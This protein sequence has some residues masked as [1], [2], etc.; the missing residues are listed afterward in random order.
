[1]PRLWKS[2]TSMVS[3]HKVVKERLRKPSPRYPRTALSN[4]RS[5]QKSEPID[6]EA[7]DA[8]RRQEPGT[9]V[10]SRR[11][12]QAAEATAHLPQD[13]PRK[14][15]PVNQTRVERYRGPGDNRVR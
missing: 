12:A 5:V 2:L 1:M 13:D 10:N 11:Q 3:P 4:A 7:R 8:A 14:V 9:S 6:K 15:A